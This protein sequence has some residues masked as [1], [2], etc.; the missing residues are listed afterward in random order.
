MKDLQQLFRNLSAQYAGQ[1]LARVLSLG[2]VLLL[3][4]ELGP[5]GYGV[6]SA[7]YAFVMLFMSW[8]DLG[9]RQLIIREVAKDHSR[10][11][12]YLRK[13]FV[14]RVGATLGIVAL[15][16]VT[17]PLLGYEHETIVFI[18][19]M[20]TAKLIDNVAKLYSG[21]LEGLERMAFSEGVEVINQLIVLGISI[22]LVFAGYSVVYIGVAFLVAAAFKCAFTVGL[23]SRVRRKLELRVSSG[24]W[25]DVAFWTDI[26][27]ESWPFLVGSALAVIIFDIDK[28]MISVMLGNAET[29]WYNSAYR[30][31]TTV[32]IVSGGFVS[33]IYPQLSRFHAGS[34]EARFNTMLD[35]AT[36]YMAALGVPMAVGTVI[37]ADEIILLFFGSEFQNSIV[38]LQALIWAQ[39]GMFVG[40]VGT[41]TIKAIDKQHVNPINAAIAATTNIAL[42]FVLIP[43]WGILGAAIA[44]VLTEIVA[45]LL[46][47][48]WLHKFHR[49]PRIGKL[50][51]IFAASAA[52]GILVHTIDTMG[53]PLPLLIV[54]GACS[55][56]LFAYTLD[57]I[58][59]SDITLFRNSVGV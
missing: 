50:P 23:Y 37:T 44:T 59:D 6:Y 49:V 51:H 17:A 1:I 18:G 10:A 26:L 58:D 21:V 3:T 52:M 46:L 11:P 13:L 43:L 7:G 38:V 48:Y 20:A 28:V 22:P 40:Q 57:I 47:S 24:D 36:K 32:G 8:S 45:I 55:Y 27:R 12:S 34:D 33:A 4:R 53:A 5:D 15:I 54:T 42:N 14:L 56:G 41:T 16:L 9:T 30:I 25:I 29:G 2:L 19:L 31:M 39:V 35:T